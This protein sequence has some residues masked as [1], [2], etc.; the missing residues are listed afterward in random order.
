LNVNPWLNAPAGLKLAGVFVYTRPMPSSDDIARA[1]DHFELFGIERKFDIDE[2]A[3]QRTLNTL[4]RLTHPDLVSHGPDQQLRA[5]ELSA[6]VNEAHRTLTDPEARANYLLELL[7]GPSK[8]QDKALPDD[9]LME[10]MTVRE[11]LADAQMS[12]DTR[13]LER[14]ETDARQRRE[15]H[16]QNVA[17]LFS[18][19]HSGDR[20]SG[21]RELFARI[22]VELNCLRYVERMLEQI[23]PSDR[24]ML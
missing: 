11:E 4:S 13:V 16:L 15:R 8:E 6:K 14:F 3:L 1:R 17:S 12:E 20:S 24:P 18:Q 22:R 10:M 19:I 5:V 9:F 21:T 2:R 23:R 7:G